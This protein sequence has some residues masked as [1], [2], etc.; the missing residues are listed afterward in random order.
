M[1]KTISIISQKGG[2]GKT[3]LA[4]HIA[5]AAHLAGL[6]AAILDLDQQASAEAWG[7][8]REDAPPEVLPAKGATLPRTLD[9]CRAA[10][11]GL[12]VLDTPGTAEGAGRAP[13]DAADL[14]L[15]PCRPAAFDLHAIQQS[16]DLARGRLAFVVFNAVPPSARAI[17][18]DARE[19]TERIGLPIA[20][21]HLAERA[22]YRR[23]TEEGKT[24]QETEPGGK[25]AAEIA[26]LWDWIC[27]QVNLPACKAGWKEAG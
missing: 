15:I 1:M 23:A 16:A 2:A 19:I 22:S 24:V 17:R 8:W 9:K 25:A 5:V 6:E 11:A 4:V 14:I 20:P 27:E 7:Q 18:A 12:I 10:G 13:V 3:T 26:G 21:V